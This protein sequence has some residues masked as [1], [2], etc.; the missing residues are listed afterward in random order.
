[1]RLSKDALENRSA[2]IGQGFDLPEFD[3]AKVKEETR[4]NPEWLHFG[5]GNIFRAFVAKAYQELLNSGEAKSGIIAAESFD[6]EVIDKI[7]E[8]YDNLSIT[9]AM[10]ADGTF[11]KSVVASIVEGFTTDISKAENLK[12]LQDIFESPTLQ[13]VSFTITE[14]GY[15][16]TNPQG[17]YLGIIKEEI[18][19]GPDSCRHT[20]SLVAAL[21][22]RRFLIGAHPLTLVSMDNCSHNGDKLKSAVL[23]ISREWAKRGLVKDEFVAYLEDEST[24][25]FPLSMIDKITPR[26]ADEVKSYLEHAGIE[27]MDTVITSKGSYMAPFVN[28]EVPGYLII[29]DKFTNGRPSLEKSGIIFTDR[30]TVNR[31]ETMKVT[32]CLNPLHTA[33]AVTGCLL[34]YTLI[35]DEV[36]DDALYGLIKKIGYDEGMKVVVDPGIVDPRAFIDE[37]IEE[38]FKNPYIPDAPQRI[39]TD[40]S[41]KVGI[42][43]GETIKS[44]DKNPELDA[45]TLVGIPLAIASW[46]RYLLAVDDEGNEFTLS[47]DPLLDELKKI[48]DGV[49]LGST[50]VSL[51]GLLSNTS[52][53]GI[54]LYD[55]G[56]GETVEKMFNEM[57]AGP[58]AVR[59]TIVKYVM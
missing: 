3:I 58:G 48:F 25:T 39:A 18:E 4:K 27:G 14:K 26:P 16:I 17:E 55:A 6:Y 22:Y 29:E 36:K 20:M 33:L 38:R 42:R 53:F 30:E 19:K 49:T 40:T 1:M 23:T 34:G 2:W 44:Y 21:C 54:D 47:S 45:S 15:A 56:I 46:C 5:A 9:V 59:K 10:H 37:V 32:T 24:V 51:R 31:V 43:F 28:A 7:Y 11:D 57:L 12:R 35:A 52:I 50:G 8:P 41:Q 13:M